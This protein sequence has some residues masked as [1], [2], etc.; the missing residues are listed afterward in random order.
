MARIPQNSVQEFKEV[1]IDD[2]RADKCY[3]VCYTV[4]VNGEHRI[5]SIIECAMFQDEFTYRRVL[6]SDDAKL[7]AS[8]RA[9]V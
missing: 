7:W 2:P 3:L 5:T 1:I 4:T 6:R 9:L 8:V